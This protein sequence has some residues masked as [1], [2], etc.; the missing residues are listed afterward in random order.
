[1]QPTV[2]RRVPPLALL[3]LALSLPLL[4]GE[5][6]PSDAPQGCADAASA[7]SGAAAAPAEEGGGCGCSAGLTRDQ[8]APAAAAAE[9]RDAEA[10]AASAAS[11]STPPRLLPVA[12]GEFIMGHNN[13]S[14]SPSTFTVDGEG[15]ARRV[16]LDSYFIGETEVSNA[17]YATF[18]AA[19]GHV[20]D[21]EKFGWSFVFQKQ[22]T[23][24]ADKES[25]QSVQEA[26]WWISVSG[27]SWR[28]PDGPGSDALALGRADH[29]VSH[30]SWTDAVAY[31]AWAYPA[32]EEGSA[33]GT[34]EG[35]AAAAG[36]AA[37][38]PG[39]LPTEAEWEY[40]ARGGGHAA[41]KK[42]TFPWGNTLTPGGEHRSNVWQGTFPTENTAE[43]GHAFAA[44]VT[45]YGPQN[46]L[47]L[48]AGEAYLGHS[49]KSD[50]P[51]GEVGLTIRLTDGGG[52]FLHRYNMIGNVWEWVHDIWTIEHP[53]SYK[54]DPPMH[55]P[56]GPPAGPER[57]KKGGSYMCHAS[58]CHRYAELLVDIVSRG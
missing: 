21:S 7:S 27:A 46:A 49:A 45:A 28:H 58:Y 17:Q 35:S 6:V 4:P 11:T 26:P 10:P 52:L 53:R 31:C 54:V 39:R 29:P 16:S 43:D 34:A 57:T 3:A 33:E 25:T 56:R 47:G 36:G 41:G 14:V 24:Q 55:N 40:A 8:P 50:S 1:M 9:P 42:R 23:P 13:R 15:P 18:A 51:F 44:P 5:S 30:V 19:T 20:S 32:A 48:Y 2:R 38:G 12:G 37:H 22:L